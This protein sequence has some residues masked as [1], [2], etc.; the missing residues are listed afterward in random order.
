MLVLAHACSIFFALPPL[1]LERVGKVNFNM[2]SVTFGKGSE[3][4]I[5]LTSK[6]EHDAIYFGSPG[7]SNIKE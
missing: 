6:S 4:W 5:G 1:V 7:A 3:R 2:F